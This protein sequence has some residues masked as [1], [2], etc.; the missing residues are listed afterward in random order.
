MHAQ[1]TSHV[2]SYSQYPPSAQQLLPIFT[3]ASLP[4]PQIPQH[5]HNVN[6]P[7]TTLLPTQPIPNPKTKF[8]Q[9]L[10][11]TEVPHSPSFD[12]NVIP[13][14]DIQLRSRSTVNRKNPV[15][16]IHEEFEEVNEENQPKEG[17]PNIL[18]NTHMTEIKHTTQ[19]HTS[20]IP[21]YPLRMDI[22]KPVARH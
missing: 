3:P 20:G 4:T 21:P 6:P 19:P 16:I 13:F 15:V 14:Q 9:P 7:R 17:N 22:E 2:P 18:D 10:N 12:I 8:P 5:Y 11:N 1:V